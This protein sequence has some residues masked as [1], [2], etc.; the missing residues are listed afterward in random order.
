MTLP[1]KPKIYHIL[2]VDRLESIITDNYLWCDAETERRKLPGT[3]IGIPH[4]K[5]RRLE[6]PINSYLDLRVGQCVPFYFCPRS[7]M[8]YIIHQRN[9]QDLAYRDGQD[10]IVHLEADLFTTVDWAK[11]NDKR[12]AFTLSNAGSKYFECRTDL[13]YLN[14][15][16]WQS[17]NS[18]H[19]GG[20]EVAREVRDQKQ[21]EF[22]MEFQ[23]PWPLIERIGVNSQLM[24][25]KVIDIFTPQCHRP[26]VEIM[27]S[28]YY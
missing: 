8:L 20:E 27:S 23:F 16:D 7:V 25:D 5:K 28:W 11:Q 22:L 1:Q 6:Q 18:T 9:H 19:W 26:K 4:I 10:H 14:A 12:W 15:L 3:K 2:H 24:H 17:I 21:A 13:K